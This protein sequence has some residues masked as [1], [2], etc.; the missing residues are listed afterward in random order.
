MY[1]VYIYIYIYI[2]VYIYIYPYSVRMRKNTDQNNSKYG[3]FSGSVKGF[4][5][6][7]NSPAFLIQLFFEDK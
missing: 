7:G 1:H 5:L 4:S 2:Y 6:R 3:H